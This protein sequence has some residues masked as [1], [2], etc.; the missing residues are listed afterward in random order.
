M[1]CYWRHSPLKWWFVGLFLFLSALALNP[2]NFSGSSPQETY[3]ASSV[4]IALVPVIVVFV[5]VV[6][7]IVF[8][9]KMDLS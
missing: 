4:L 5:F 6:G 1:G 2:Y 3:T 8:S 9:D 7:L